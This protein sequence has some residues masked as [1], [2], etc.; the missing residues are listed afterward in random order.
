MIPQN[1]LKSITQKNDEKILLIVMDGLGGLPVEGK[2]E[3]ETAR[4]PN[5]DKLARHSD[6]G[7]SLAC[8]YGVTPGSG[9]GHLGLFGYD[10]FVYPIGR[11]I[12]EALGIGLHMTD[13]DLAMRANFAT[14][15]KNR[16]V[17]DRRAGRIP[18][19]KNQ[20]LCKILQEKI[21]EID[22]VKVTIKPGKEHRFVVIFRGED[23]DDGLTDCDPQKEGK[24]IPPAKALTPAS[25]RSQRI[26]NSFLVK[27]QQILKDEPKAN[28]ALLRGFAKMPPIPSMEELFKLTPCCI[29]TY[30]MYKGLAKLVGMEILK[31]GE[32]MADQ[33]QALKDNYQ[34]FDFF[35]FHYKYTDSRGE[36][37]DFQA[38]V[39]AIEEFDKVLPEI[40]KYNFKAVAVTGDHS[41]PASMKSH[42][43]HP[44][45]LLISGPCTMEDDLKKF[46]ERE[47][48]RGSL[49]VI[50]AT[51]ILPL[52][53]AQAGKL[54]KYGA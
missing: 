47:C 33:L 41:T 11:G 51:S 53:M 21:K 49:G 48:R 29:A 20:E 22:G 43:W 3:L 2:T 25:E 26:V 1:V 4:T 19:E 45:P 10:P 32:T 28:A 42:S 46:S 12:L 34:K 40:L 8:A 36:D 7:R 39:K 38:K 9:P 44:S 31:T 6:C 13:L 16:I 14:V 52:L 30:P 54:Q 27:L 5:L 24:P 17:T 18:T 15:D 35:F 50:P 23:L 37:G